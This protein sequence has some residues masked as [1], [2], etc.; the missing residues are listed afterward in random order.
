M[1]CGTCFTDGCGISEGMRCS[2]LGIVAAQAGCGDGHCGWR[3]AARRLNGGNGAD[4][5]GLIRSRK[6]AGGAILQIA[7]E[8]DI[9]II[10]TRDDIRVCE[11]LAAMD[12]VDLRCEVH[13]CLG[14]PIYKCGVV[15]KGAFLR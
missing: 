14:S 4:L 6:V 2:G 5:I 1:A 12:A 15:A 3:E 8:A 7:G 9:L 10:D 13:G 11:I